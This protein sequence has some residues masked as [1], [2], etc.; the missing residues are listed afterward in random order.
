[1]AGRHAR[2][3]T[4]RTKTFVARSEE[5]APLTAHFPRAN[6]HSDLRLA[7][8]PNP[9]PPTLSTPHPSNLR[10]PYVPVPTRPATFSFHISEL[11]FEVSEVDI[12]IDR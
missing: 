7:A 10:V 1:M 3:V 12:M 9:P 5:Q 8:V 2:S 6:I 11:S 4:K